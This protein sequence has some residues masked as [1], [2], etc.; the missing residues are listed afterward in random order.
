MEHTLGGF[1]MVQEPVANGGRAELDSPAM[2]E[3]GEPQAAT[4]TE[5]VLDHTSENK[6][7]PGVT[8]IQMGEMVHVEL[9]T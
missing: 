4:L 7:T 1:Q 5:I 3:S 8:K 9:T 6:M 2:M